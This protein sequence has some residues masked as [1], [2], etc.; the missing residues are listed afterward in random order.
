LAGADRGNAEA[1]SDQRSGSRIARDLEHGAREMEDELHH[2]EDDLEDAERKAA[3]RRK[4]A[5]SGSASAPPAPGEGAPDRAG[6]A[7][8]R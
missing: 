1:M 8:R 5:G 7:R 2:L 3:E 4:D 6:R